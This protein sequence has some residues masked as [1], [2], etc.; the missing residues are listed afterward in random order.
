MKKFI[1]AISFCAV[2]AVAGAAQAATVLVTGSNRGIGLEFVKQYAAQGWT[3]IA[4]TRN[5]ADA[6]DLQALAAKDKKITVEKLDLLDVE[7]I[8]ALGAKYKGKSIT[9]S[10]SQTK[11]RISRTKVR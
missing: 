11:C 7:G 3:V 5:P 1:A 10:S 8:R 6:K 4:T 9:C 2:L